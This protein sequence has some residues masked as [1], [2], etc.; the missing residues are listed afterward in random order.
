MTCDD[1][2][3]HQLEDRVTDGHEGGE[4]LSGSAVEEGSLSTADAR[5]TVRAIGGNFGGG[6][7]YTSDINVSSSREMWR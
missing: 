2:I 6:D 4:R 3:T 7:L 5:A 1:V